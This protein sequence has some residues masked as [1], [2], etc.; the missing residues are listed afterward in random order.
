MSDDAIAALLVFGLSLGG[1][2][3]LLG[4]IVLRAALHRDD[5]R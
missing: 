2:F 5:E 3:L 4:A 1:T